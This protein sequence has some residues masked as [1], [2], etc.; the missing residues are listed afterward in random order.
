MSSFEDLPAEMAADAP[1]LVVAGDAVLDRWWSGSSARL[2]REA[3]VP[4]VEVLDRRAAAGGAG[5]AAVNAAAMGARVRFVGPVGSDGA[6]DEVV[7]LLRSAGVDVTGVRRSAALATDVKTRIVADG[8]VL[9]RADDRAP[10]LGGDETAH[11]ARE[12]ADAL[13]TALAGADAL[14]VSDYGS[15]L[16]ETAVAGAVAVHRPATVVVDAHDPAR[17]RGIR[18]NV[19][20]PNALEAA[21]LVGTPLGTG[22]GRA[23][24]AAGLADRLLAAANATAAVVTLDRD[25]SVAL[26]PGEPPATTTAHPTAEMYASGA[27]DTFAAALTTALA[28]GAPLDGAAWVAQQAADVVVRAFGTTVCTAE[29]LAEQATAAAPS[30]MSHTALAEA[31][32]Q[33]RERGLRVVFTNGCFDVLHLGHTTYLREAKRLGDRLIVAVNADAS[34]RRLKGPDRP[35]NGETDRAAVVAALE[36]VDYVTVFDG[37]TPISLIQS[38]RPDVYVKGGDYTPDMLPETPAVL[39]YG[40]EVRTVG[41]VAEH[42]TTSM[43]DRI[44]TAAEGS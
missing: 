11:L 4:V 2:S 7:A 31:V 42:S 6:G 16:L 26:C 14:L 13:A 40:G 12:L 20:V 36:C 43:V 24:A 37:D 41:Y 28:V 38:L 3:P 39:A 27:G 25:G 5:N 9:V 22:R 21:A 10:G 29:A 19:V 30:A 17:W 32:A 34:V 33:D 35:V 1:L 44:R 15:G 8:Q 18:P 23:A